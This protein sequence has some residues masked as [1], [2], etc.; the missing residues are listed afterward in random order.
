M[1]VWG[2]MLDRGSGE[3]IITEDDIRLI[4]YAHLL[5]EDEYDNLK[6]L[7]EDAYRGGRILSTDNKPEQ[8]KNLG[9][10][11][12]LSDESKTYYDYF[13][14]RDEKDDWD[15]EIKEIISAI[16]VLGE[17]KKGK[18]EII[19]YINNIKKAALKDN[20]PE[21]NGK[22]FLTVARYVYL[23]ERMHAFF[24]RKGAVYNRDKEEGLAEFG[25]LLLLDELVNTTP[26]GDSKPKVYHASKEELDWA[27][28]HVESKK[29]AL[30]CYAR[31]AYLFNLFGQ[32]KE[33]SRKMLEAY[34]KD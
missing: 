28:R 2:S 22:D 34:P 20:A 6:S 23:H 8:T 29:G 4:D 17:Y 16:C 19:L 30:E 24:E 11:V 15:E 12:I 1:S 7:L 33:L 32:N 14:E 31:G 27:V 18:G 5:L 9:Q 10:T 25:A 3:T 13:N 26:N 21:Y